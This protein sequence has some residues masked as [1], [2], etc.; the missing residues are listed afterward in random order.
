MY[1][2]VRRQIGVHG[3]ALL[4]MRD[5]AEHAGEEGL[6]VTIGSDNEADRRAAIRNAVDVATAMPPSLPHDNTADRRS[7]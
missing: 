2:P 4:F 7:T 5:E 6:A 3:P 1:T